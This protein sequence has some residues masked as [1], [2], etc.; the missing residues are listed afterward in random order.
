MQVNGGSILTNSGTV[1]GAVNVDGTV[2]G[3]GNF[4]AAVTVNDRGVFSAAGT[5]SGLLTVAP[6][7]TVT[8][9]NGT[10]TVLG[11]VVN[12]GTIRLESGATFVLG[13]GSTMTG[14]G[15]L[16]V[17]RGRYIVPGGS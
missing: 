13:S 17:A 11:N 9:R 12:E 2:Q 10:L 1:S 7:G 6:G 16:D 5:I 15:T 3:R 14:H 8:L 4:G